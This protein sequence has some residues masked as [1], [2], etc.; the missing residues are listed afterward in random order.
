MACGGGGA[1][2]RIY[3]FWKNKNIAVLFLFSAL[4]GVFPQLIYWKLI[5]GEWLFYSYEADQTFSFLKPH[6]INFLF[7]YTKG[8][9]TYTPVM[10]L[11]I[12][13]FYFLLKFKRALFPAIFSFFI[14]N[15]YIISAW[16]CWWYGGSFTQR[17]II[18]SY[19]LMVFPIASLLHF[20]KR[21]WKF[22]TPVLV[23]ILGCTWLNLFMTYQ[24]IYCEN[25]IHGDSMTKAYFWR[26][27]GKTSVNVH[28][29]M[30]LDTEEQIPSKDTASLKLIATFDFEDSTESIETIDVNGNK[31]LTMNRDKQITKKVRL[32]LPSNA[33]WIRAKIHFNYPWE[34]WNFWKWTQ[35]YISLTSNDGSTKMNMV[36]CQRQ[37]EPR[38]WGEVY[39]DIKNEKRENYKWIEIQFNNATSES[40]VYID[41]LKVY[42]TLN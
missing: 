2:E 15:L 32:E 14:V 10:Y 13:G 18:Q 7:S 19:A 25:I 30:M 26:V 37:V 38:T 29:K 28:D 16:D 1:K 27:F 6:L 20:T 42:A 24:V 39:V 3:F 22:W 17:A 4:I 5:S 33:K 31:M 11:S 9:F 12:I 21:N 40:L 41:D 8:W 35:F 36:R 34:E 23:F